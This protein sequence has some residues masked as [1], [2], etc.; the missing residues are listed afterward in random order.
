MWLV[1]TEEC[2][3]VVSKKGKKTKYIYMYVCMYIYEQITIIMR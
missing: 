3:S 1:Q 2:E